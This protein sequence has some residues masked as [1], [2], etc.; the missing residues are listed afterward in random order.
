MHLL[1][2]P[3]V[4]GC[5]WSP[6]GFLSTE[7]PKEPDE[8]EQRARREQ[9]LLARRARRQERRKRQGS[10]T[11]SQEGWETSDAWPGIAEQFWF[12]WLV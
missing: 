8:S 10:E 3:S 6:H 9:A 11:R 4:L 5:I 2:T 7:R 1:Q 12:G